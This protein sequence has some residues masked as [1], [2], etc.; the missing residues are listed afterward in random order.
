MRG[1]SVISSYKQQLKKVN[2][3]LAS[4][5]QELLKIR[6]SI[7][8]LQKREALVENRIEA[9][10]QNKATK[11]ML[12]FSGKERATLLEKAEQ[13]QYSQKAIDR[14]RDFDDQHWNADFVDYNTIS[15]FEDVEKY[16]NDN[17]PEWERGL[18]ARIG[19]HFL[20]NE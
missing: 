15:D 11:G 10:R 17:E 5:E 7:A 16:V 20:Q 12:R 19:K 2:K 9:G 18:F 3:S 6:A 8:A 4:D 14:L 1:V 13:L